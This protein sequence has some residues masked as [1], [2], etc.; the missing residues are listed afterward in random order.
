VDGPVQAAERVLR[1]GGD[2]WYR[3]TGGSVREAKR[4][5]EESLS[6]LKMLEEQ[7]RLRREAEQA[8]GVI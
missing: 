5:Q 8:R 3:A 2:V 1:W 6:A 7:N 4:Q